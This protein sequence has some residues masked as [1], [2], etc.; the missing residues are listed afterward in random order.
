M[1]TIPYN[2]SM[3]MP[4]F[5]MA[6]SSCA[7]H[8]FTTTYKGFEANFFQQETVLKLHGRRLLREDKEVNVNDVLSVDEF[9]AKENHHQKKK[10][11]SICRWANSRPQLTSGPFGSSTKLLEF[12]EVREDDE[13]IQTA[14]S[15]PDATICQGPLT[16]D[17]SPPLAKDE[18]AP[19][20]TADNQAELMRWHYHLGHLHFPKLKLAINGKIPKKLAKVTPPKCAGCL[21]CAKTKLPWRGKEKKSSHLFVATKPGETVSVDQMASTEVGFF[22][23]LKGTLTKKRYRCATIF[24]DHYS[25]LQFVHLQINDSAIETITA[26]RAFE[27]F[28]TKQGVCIQHYHC[29]N[30]QFYDNAF[31][32]ACH[33]SRQHLTFCGVNAHFQKWHRRACNSQCQR[34]RSEAITPCL[35]SMASR[36]PLWPMAICP[37]QRGPSPQQFAC[38]GRWHIKVGDV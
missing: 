11:S 4:I 13:T 33:E 26:K 30:G 32:K 31:Q 1:K 5:F 12:E 9:I 22:A 18:D 38:A 29:N 36:Y 10:G 17:P 3:N 8:A 15:A 24:V 35:R 20:A 16:F 6:P 2:P 25:C 23:Q 21:F 7:Y 37:A 14:N 28:A 27:A 19:L 34:E